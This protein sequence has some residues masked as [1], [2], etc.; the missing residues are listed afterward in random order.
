[1]ATSKMVKQ[2]A[3]AIE[4]AGYN[5]VT[6]EHI[7]EIAINAMREPTINMMIAGRKAQIELL[8]SSPNAMAGGVRGA[9]TAMIDEA[10]R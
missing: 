3:R 1:M 8:Q 4:E 9:W 5:P 7:A 10:V 6:A 2:V